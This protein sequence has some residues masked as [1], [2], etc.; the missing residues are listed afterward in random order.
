MNTLSY[1]ISSQ[2]ILADRYTPVNVYMKVRDI[3]AQSCLMESSDYQNETNSHSI[4]G[5]NPIASFSVGHGKARLK[6]PD[7]PETIREISAS[8]G[9]EE[10][11]AEFMGR[12]SVEGDTSGYCGLYGYTAFDAV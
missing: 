11:F 6:W 4:I 2:R 5:F 9:V 10:A 12:F 8:Y 1:H 7:E 3:Y